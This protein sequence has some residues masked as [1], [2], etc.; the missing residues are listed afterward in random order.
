MMPGTMM[1]GMAA[2]SM[3]VQGAYGFSPYYGYNQ[4]TMNSSY[5]DT[6][7]SN[8]MLTQQKQMQQMMMAQSQGRMGPGMAGYS[9]MSAPGGRPHGVQGGYGTHYV[10]RQHR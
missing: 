4:T 6:P 5:W 7:M 9:H 10:T 2:P 1:P 8:M 3:G